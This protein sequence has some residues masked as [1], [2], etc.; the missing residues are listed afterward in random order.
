MTTLTFLPSFLSIMLVAF[1]AGLPTGASGSSVDRWDHSYDV[2]AR[3]NVPPPS[4]S[5][6]GGPGG[7]FGSSLIHYL[8]PLWPPSPSA[9]VTQSGHPY[10]ETRISAIPGQVVR[11]KQ[12]V[13]YFA[14][15]ARP[16]VFYS[17]ITLFTFW[18][19]YGVRG[20]YCTSYYLARDRIVPISGPSNP[21][22]IPPLEVSPLTPPSTKTELSC[23]IPSRTFTT[24][25]ERPA[26]PTP[27]QARLKRGMYAYEDEEEP[28]LP[29]ASSQL[30]A[31]IDKYIEFSMYCP[32]SR[33]WEL[34]TR[35]CDLAAKVVLLFVHLDSALARFRLWGLGLGTVFGIQVIDALVLI[36]GFILMVILPLK[37]HLGYFNFDQPSDDDRRSSGINCDPTVHIVVHHSYQLTV[38][39][40]RFEG[41]SLGY[42]SEWVVSGDYEDREVLEQHGWADVGRTLR[43]LE[44]GCDDDLIVVGV[45]VTRTTQA[46]DVLN[47][48]D[49]EIMSTR[50]D[51]LC[52]GPVSFWSQTWFVSDPEVVP[53]YIEELSETSLDSFGN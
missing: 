17:R 10:L 51:E 16:P 48:S 38:K 31:T 21:P 52:T 3:L 50:V 43:L 8:A 26:L 9:L 30:P 37:V 40:E 14:C 27:A 23:L 29:P 45:E 41:N 4:N 19:V 53:G 15:E 36:A 20:R 46:F 24:S 34:R 7:H 42:T 44:T 35:L 22:L 47:F 13:L 1:I 12:S 25:V 32:S 11:A 2:F 28:T 5:T 33:P 39:A 49:I 6:Y 18:A